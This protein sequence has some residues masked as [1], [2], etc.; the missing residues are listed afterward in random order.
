MRGNRAHVVSTVLGE[1]SAALRPRRA[2]I[3][4]DGR[5]GTPSPRAEHSPQLESGRRIPTGF[6]LKAQGSSL[7]ATLGWRTQSLRDWGRRECAV[8]KSTR[9]RY[10]A[11]QY[12]NTSTAAFSADF[13]TSSNLESLVLGSLSL[14]AS[15]RRFIA[16]RFGRLQ[17]PTLARTLD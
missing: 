3:S 14:A 12:T 9:C 11:A 1:P 4:R 13:T 15:V 17:Y 7:L 16:H 8:C 6:R 5:Q 10:L 2:S